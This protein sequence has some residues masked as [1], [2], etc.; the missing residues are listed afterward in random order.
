[1]P[2]ISTTPQQMAFSILGQD[3]TTGKVVILGDRE[4][5]RGIYC[6]GKTGQGKTTWME[7]M[8]LQD[9]EK[10]GGCFIDAHGDA[11]LHLLSRIPEHRVNDVILLDINDVEFPWG[12]NPLAIDTPDAASL[13]QG[14]DRL[15]HIFEKLWGPES[16]E[17]AWGPQLENVLRNCAYT[18]VENKATLAELPL[19]LRDPAFRSQMLRKVTNR[20]V[21]WFWEEDFRR[22]PERM[23]IERTESTLN[24]VLDF[25]VKQTVEHIIGQEKTTVDFRKIMDEGKIL[26]VRIPANDVGN[27]VVKLIGTMLIAELLAAALSRANIPEDQ[28][29]P[30]C[31][32]IDEYQNYSSQDTVKLLAEARKFSI[33]SCVSHQ[34]R[35][36]FRPNDPNRGATLNAGTLV[37]F[38]VSGEDA[39]ELA[40][41]FDC[42][43]PPAPLDRREKVLTLAQDVVG[44]LLSLHGH[45]NPAVHLFTEQILRKL[46]EGSKMKIKIEVEGLHEIPYYPSLGMGS[47]FHPDELHQAL[48]NI[49]NPFLYEVM[50]QQNP[51]IAIP[52]S[53]LIPIGSACGFSGTYAHGTY[54]P[55]LSPDFLELLGMPGDLHK[56]K[57]ALQALIL[58]EIWVKPWVAYIDQFPT[59]WQAFLETVSKPNSRR[60]LT[61]C[62]AMDT[63]NAKREQMELNEGR[64]VAWTTQQE[65]MWHLAFDAIKIFDKLT[66]AGQLAITNPDVGQTTIER[67]AKMMG[68]A[69]T[70]HQGDFLGL[71]S[72]AA[73]EGKALTSPQAFLQYFMRRKKDWTY[74]FTPAFHNALAFLSLFRNCIEALA[75]EPIMVDSGK[76]QMLPGTQRSFSD[77]QNEIANTLK[78][79]PPY[80]AKVKLVTSRAGQETVCEHTIRTPIKD[81]GLSG[82]ALLARIDRI[83]RQTRARY[84]TPREEVQKA[85]RAR[86][87][88]RP[89]PIHPPPAPTSSEEPQAHLPTKR[90]G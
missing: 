62:E 49:L 17:M 81:T 72:S 58:L 68:V 19:L 80:H 74:E 66:G 89:G 21:K 13:D 9:F 14:V 71:P 45:T 84:C 70:V 26:L 75:A 56:K 12:L 42:T 57:E 52:L 32:Y 1:M 50:K 76:Y 4:R 90:R 46:V 18:L 29:R 51:H 79:L 2:A 5:T 47:S 67:R 28:R 22:W 44:H 11:I 64:V 3:I 59:F 43:P 39:D 30:F 38:Q 16:N 27:E 25:L 15:L 34:F 36:Q 33:L 48:Y 41:Q 88:Q 82:Q 31:L 85:I 23:V 86:Q 65:A 63:R 73:E 61:Y 35:G 55:L 77:M 7:N 60:Y 10:H 54:T 87:D 37:V 6:I 8:A 20:W 40:A 78:N 83:Q 69:V 53:L 24:K